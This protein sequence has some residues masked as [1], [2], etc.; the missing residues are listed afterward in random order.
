MDGRFVREEADGINYR[1]G[2]SIGTNATRPR[3]GFLAPPE[4]SG[5]L[6]IGLHQVGEHSGQRLDLADRWVTS[7]PTPSVTT[8]EEATEAASAYLRQ[9]DD[10]KYKQLA[11]SAGCSDRLERSEVFELGEFTVTIVD[12]LGFD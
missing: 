1:L 4:Q 6:V 12:P 8:I 11:S 9:I 7:A 3:V 10:A 5:P 2:A